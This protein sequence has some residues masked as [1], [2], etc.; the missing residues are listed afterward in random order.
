MKTIYYVV[1]P[2]CVGKTTLLRK[3]GL[4]PLQGVIPQTDSLKLGQETIGWEDYD[5]SSSMIKRAKKVGYKVILIDM[6]IL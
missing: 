2:P 1:G 3:L 4:E 6:S 5:T